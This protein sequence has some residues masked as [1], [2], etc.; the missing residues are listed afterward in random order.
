[1]HQRRGES[2]LAPFR[3]RNGFCQGNHE[4]HASEP[5]IRQA[6][7]IAPSIPVVARV[8]HHTSVF[9]LARAGA[10]RAVDDESLLGR[11]LASAA[12][13]AIGSAL[14]AIDE[15]VGNDARPQS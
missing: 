1:M 4:P 6:K 3:L 8:R 5:T 10:D 2:Q 9:T 12:K 11:E 7:R 13:E 14:D 15:D